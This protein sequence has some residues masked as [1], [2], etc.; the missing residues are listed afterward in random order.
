MSKRTVSQFKDIGIL[1]GRD[2]NKKD[3]APQKD[4]SLAKEAEDSDWQQ[5]HAASE[6]RII[7]SYN[8]TSKEKSQVLEYIEIY[9]RELFE[10]LW[11]VN[12][13]ITNNNLWDSFSEIRSLNDH[14]DHKRIPGILP[15]FYGIV[16]KV[17]NV[18]GSNGAPL[19]KS[20]KY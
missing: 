14:G 15:R 7:S 5:E 8:L 20:E 1:I 6:K 19:D 10:E 13:Y 16:C 18:S 4:K 17:L 11:Q 2:S 12:R 3:F 9:K